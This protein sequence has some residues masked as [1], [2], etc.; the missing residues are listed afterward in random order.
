MIELRSPNV[1]VR[2]DEIGARIAQ[3]STSLCRNLLLERASRGQH[4]DPETF[5]SWNATYLGGWDLLLPSVGDIHPRVVA[6]RHYHGEAS[7]RIWDVVEAR[8][9]SALLVCRLRSI[10]LEVWRRVNVINGEVIVSTSITNT[11]DGDVEFHFCEHIAFDA[12]FAASPVS[13]AAEL[14]D[15]GTASTYRSI[16]I[17]A[18]SGV[19]Q[20]GLDVGVAAEVR[21]NPRE[22]A[23]CVLWRELNSA[24][25]PWFGSLRTVAIEPGSFDPANTTVVLLNSG[26]SLKYEVN[27]SVIADR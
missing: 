23:A 25:A 15:S 9:S 10:P 4:K 21:W 16:R 22:V 19:A 27:L 18:A 12:R 11:S 7:R 8:S 17:A 13:V 5:D 6:K 24:Q 2:L 1:E 3:I 20:I 14:V 26:A